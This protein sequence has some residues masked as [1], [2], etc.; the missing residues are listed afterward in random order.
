[1]RINISPHISI[2]LLT[3]KDDVALYK[4]VDANRQYLMEWLPWLDHVKSI[5]DSQIFIDTS[6]YRYNAQENANFAVVY[7]QNLIGIAG[8][9]VLDY[10]NRLAAIGY[11]LDRQ[12]QGLGIMTKVVNTLVDYGF[13]DQKLNKIEIR[14]AEQNKKSRAIAE[15]LGF[16]FEAKIRQCE[17]LYDHFVDHL[18]YSKLAC[19][20]KIVNGQKPQ[21]Y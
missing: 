10:S 13:T 18:V 21:G 1:M 14:C 12:H 8:F 9:N 6:I 7:K 16:T 17:W 3:P 4:L 5:R 11:W 15:R 19:E 2:R 20:Y